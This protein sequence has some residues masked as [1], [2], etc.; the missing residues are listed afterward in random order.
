MGH[1]DELLF[2]SLKRMGAAGN[3]GDI[4]SAASVEAFREQRMANYIEQMRYYNSS[5]SGAGSLSSSRAPSEV[6]REDY[7]ASRGNSIN[8]LDPYAEDVK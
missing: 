2:E 3:A 1:T 6:G 4:G 7:G 5:Q 8:S